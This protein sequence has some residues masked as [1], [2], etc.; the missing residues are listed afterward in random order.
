MTTETSKNHIIEAMTEKGRQLFLLGQLS[1]NDSMVSYYNQVMRVR[2][3][4]GIERMD[5]SEFKSSL[6]S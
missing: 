3:L 5:Y 2:K 1:C 6:S 4:L